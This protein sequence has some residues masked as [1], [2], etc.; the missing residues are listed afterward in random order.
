M[1]KLI[2]IIGL[3]ASGKTT[4]I[5]QNKNT[6]LKDYQIY[7]DFINIYNK[8][9]IYGRLVKG[10][11]LC[12]ADPRLCDINTFYNFINEFTNDSNINITMEDIGLI[13]FKNNPMLSQKRLTNDNT[14]NLDD[15]NKYLHDIN[16]YTKVY[17]LNNYN[18]FYIIQII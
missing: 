16:E 6:I 2:L 17:N 8:S 4:F 11:K 18:D 3:P 12:L 9:D 10:E 13:L 5:N 15:K 7:D 1:A 14:R